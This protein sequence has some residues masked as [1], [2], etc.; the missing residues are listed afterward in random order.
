MLVI[1]YGE[2]K[3]CNLLVERIMEWNI[4]V[5]GKSLIKYELNF[6]L[7]MYACGIVCTHCYIR[8]RHIVDQ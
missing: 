4:E 3:Q 2:G 1:F 6:G 8:T 7:L 5:G